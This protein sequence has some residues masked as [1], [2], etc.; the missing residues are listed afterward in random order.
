[1]GMIQYLCAVYS[2]C[3]SEFGLSTLP[4]PTT[5]TYFSTHT[6]CNV[7]YEN[8]MISLANVCEGMLFMCV[9]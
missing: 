6:L 8:H 5:P 3:K 1:M 7:A 9:R 2:Y 4:H